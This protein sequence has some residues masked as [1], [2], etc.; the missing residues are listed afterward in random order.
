MKSL[1]VKFAVTTITIMVVSGLLSFMFS[2][3]YYQ[4]KLKPYN[5]EKITNIALEMSDYIESNRDVQLHQ[6]LENIASVGYQMFIVD[7]EGNKSFFGDPFRDRTLSNDTVQ[8]VLNGDIFHG[9]LQFP[10]ETFVT[11]FFA[12]ELSNTI[13]VPI[14]HHDKHY[15]LFIR[16][17]I[18][19]MFNEMHILFAWLLIAMIILSII[20]VLIST[21]Y[22]VNPITKLKTA[23]KH[24]SEGDYSIQLEIDRKDEMGE[25]A[26]SFTNMVKK[27]EKLDDMRTEFIGNI[28]HD[29][30]SPLS[31]IK[32]YVQLLEKDS[33]AKEEKE[34]YVSIIHKEINRLSKLTDQLLLLAS[35]DRYDGLM[36]KQ[37][38][39]LSEQLKE[40]I[41]QYQWLI[42]DKELTVTYELPETS[43]DGDQSLLYNVWENLLTNAIKYNREN[44]SIDIKIK[45]KHDLIEVYFKDEG[46]GIDKSAQNRIFDRF[47]REDAARD[48]M[49]GGSGLGLSIVASIVTLHEG[50]IHVESEK[51]VGTT[52]IVTLDSS[53]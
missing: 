40:I 2:N 38:F 15:A 45:Q 43:I 46:I 28:T 20:L 17:N 52:F 53:D 42:H 39:S 25:L 23:T 19:M 29:I 30:Q 32:G 6:Y 10:Q 26:I 33:I 3:F 1:Y 4:Q 37:R 7:D 13:G 44:G 9:I 47:Y 5:D 31:N 27:L 12:N 48:R 34:Q 8:S 36:K 14:K 50:R 16:P 41:Y 24:I 11:G 35:L 21:K 22:L 51:G 18:K 49:V